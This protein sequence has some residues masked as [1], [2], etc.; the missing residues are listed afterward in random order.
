MPLVLALCVPVAVFVAYVASRPGAFRFARTRLIDAPPEKVFA[1]IND[2]HA[3]G[4]WSPW[5]R[6]DPAMKKTYDGPDAGVGAR[7]SWEGPKSGAGSMTIT[8][9]EPEARVELALEFVKPFPAHNVATFTLTPDG[10]KTRVEW[11][12]EGDRN[13][14][15]K[16]FDVVVGMDRMLGKDFTAGLDAM[17]AAAG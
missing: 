10:E 11:A 7:A 3:W 4:Q 17:A 8:A 1:L 12:M 14:M 15:M 16:A 2:L 5:E 9:S 13:F 6:L